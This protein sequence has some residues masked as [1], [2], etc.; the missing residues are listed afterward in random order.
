MTGNGDSRND[1]EITIKQWTVKQD[2]LQAF[3]EWRQREA[4]KFMQQVLGQLVLVGLTDTQQNIY[5]DHG[6]SSSGTA[7]YAKWCGGY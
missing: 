3:A 5:S 1:N 2:G 4:D 6:I 7:K